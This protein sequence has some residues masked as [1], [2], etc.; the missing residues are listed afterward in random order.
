MPGHKGGKFASHRR[1]SPL[2]RKDIRGT[3]QC[4]HVMA[5]GDKQEGKWKGN[6]RMEWVTSTLHTASEH[7]VSSIT[8]ADAYTS[9]ANSRLNWHTCRYKWTRPFHWKM[10]SGFC[11]CAIT[12][13]TKFTHF[14]LRLSQPRGH[15]EARRIMS[16]QNSSDTVRNRTRN[17]QAFSPVSLACNHL[18]LHI[19]N[20]VKFVS[21]HTEGQD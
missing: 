21:A 19:C 12:F 17:L 9:A 16:M 6:W 10:K 7:G 14:Y 13:Q 4:H 5:H 15:S 2:P 18:P 11:A 8:T 20:Y 1:Q 3:V